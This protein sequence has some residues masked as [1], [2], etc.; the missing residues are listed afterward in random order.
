MGMTINRVDPN[1]NYCP[2]NCHWATN[3]QQALSRRPRG[4]G[5]ASQDTNKQLAIDYVG[6]KYANIKK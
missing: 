3:S 6:Q 2:D 4:I 1:G 5:L